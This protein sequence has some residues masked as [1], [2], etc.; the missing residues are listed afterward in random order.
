MYD[1]VTWSLVLKKELKQIVG[2][3]GQ[4]AGEN[5]LV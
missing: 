5:T 1:P 2:V 4:V 3:Q